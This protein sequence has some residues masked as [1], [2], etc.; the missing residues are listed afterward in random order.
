[1]WR[2]CPSISHRHWIFL[3]HSLPSHL[4]NC[5]C[6]HSHGRTLLLVHQLEAFYSS[7]I[8]QAHQCMFH[9]D[10]DTLSI[11]Q[12]CDLR[13]TQRC[14]LRHRCCHKETGNRKSHHNR[15]YMCFHCT[16]RTSCTFHRR[17]NTGTTLSKFPRGNL[18]C[19][20]YRKGSSNPPQTSCS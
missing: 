16:W 3:A 1:M 6:N 20:C 15:K 8:C 9:M 5:P 18:C 19:I 13:R 2:N 4:D 14:T 7:S 17:A 12:W 11:W 10:P